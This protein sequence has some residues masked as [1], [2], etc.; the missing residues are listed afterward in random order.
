MAKAARNP[1]RKRWAADLL[2]DL[3]YAARNLAR[4]PAF[5]VAAILTLAIGIG[6][7]AAIFSVVNGVVLRP[8][9]FAEPDRLVQIYGSSPLMPSRDAVNRFND[10]QQQATSFEMMTGYDVGARYLRTDSGVER[11]MTV[12]AQK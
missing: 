5:A 9:P 1:E 2:Q 11:V 12:R 4:S 10:V 7:N 8:L 6:A 3:R